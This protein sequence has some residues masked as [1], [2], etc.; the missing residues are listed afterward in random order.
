MEHEYGEEIAKEHADEDESDAAEHEQPPR[1][2]RIE[3]GEGVFRRNGLQRR[4]RSVGHDGL[5]DS[6][7]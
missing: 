1:A 6:L 4:G 3:R 7:F 5:L 2:E